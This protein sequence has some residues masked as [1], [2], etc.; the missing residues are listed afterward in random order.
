MKCPICN[1]KKGKR[2][3]SFTTNCICSSCCGAVRK[4]ETCQNCSYYKP[5]KHNYKN[6]PFYQ[7]NEMDGYFDREEI[8]NEIEAALAT[9]DNATN[10]LMRD[11]DAIRIIEMLFDTY[12]FNEPHVVE[13][14]GLLEN[15]YQCVV[16]AIKENLSS[17]NLTELIKILGAIYFVARRRNSG[18]R[19]YLSII[20]QYVGINMGDGAKILIIEKENFYAVTRDEN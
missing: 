16:S 7:P 4:N 9:Y 8:A 5:I 11:D 3:C 14:N 13:T 18:K 10:D 2:I 12:Y 6:I 20:R 15:G 1:S 17:V 19:D